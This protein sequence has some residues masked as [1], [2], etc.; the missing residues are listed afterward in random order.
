MAR[1]KGATTAQIAIAWVKGMSGRTREVTFED[2]NK[3]K[4]QL[5]KII[6]IPGA[7]SV[8][9]VEE[10]FKDL[11]LSE[12]DMKH[13]D[14]LVEKFPVQGDRYHAQGMKHVNG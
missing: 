14:E 12:E 3:K 1:E 6:P 9:R 5:G 10:N 13:L 8:S 7:S 2:G 4:I 11:T